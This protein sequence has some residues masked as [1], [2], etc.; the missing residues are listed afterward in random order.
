MHQPRP[1]G[2]F[3]AA[4][5]EDAAAAELL[6]RRVTN[7]KQLSGL[8]S[9]R[10]ARTLP[11]GAIAIA[12]DM[13]GVFKVIVQPRVLERPPPEPTDGL[14]RSFIPMLF[15]GA[16]D[17]GRVRNDL[18]ASQREGIEL[19][20]SADT[21]RRLAGYDPE[22]AAKI[23]ERVKLQR[24]VVELGQ[25]FAELM[26]Y[27]PPEV[28]T[29]TQYDSLRPTWYSGAM[30]EVVQIVGGYGRQDF[31]K[32]PD[33]PLERARMALPA[34][35]LRA[36][37]NELGNRRL[38][39]YTGFPHEDGQIRYDYKYNE[40]HAVGFDGERKP[41][42]LRIS[43]A[44]VYAMPLPMIP[45]TTTMAFRKHVEEKQDEELKWV[46][47]RFGGLP[48]GEG[49]PVIAKDF[50]AWRRAGVITQV[51][52][53]GD[54]YQHLMYTSAMGW[55]LNS[56]GTE[57]FNTCHDYDEATQVSYSYGY[58]LRLS[59]GA[60]KDQGKLPDAF[61]LK[62][63]EQS[64]MLDAYLSRLY[65][66]L[67]ANGARELAIKYK[68]RRV[69][70]AELLQR[71]EKAL[72]DGASVQAEVDHWDN[73]QAPPIASHGGSVS[74]V[75]SGPVPWSMAGFKLPE[76]FMQGCISYKAPVKPKPGHGV[77]KADTI[78][79]GYYVGDQLKVIKY[80]TDE[81]Q[82]QRGVEDNY[83]DCM[84]VGSW[85]RTITE[86]MTGLMGSY[87]TSDFDEREAAADTTT[88]IH[89]VGTDLGYDTKP[90]FSYDEWFWRPGTIWR[91]R[92]FKHLTH[93]EKVTGYSRTVA[94]CMPYLARNA[95]LHARTDSYTGKAITDDTG[96]FHITDP[97]SYRYWT[98]DFVWAWIGGVGGPQAAV[99]V[100]PK[101]GNPVW[102]VQENY[103]PGL[104]SDFA[105][106]GPWIPGLPADYTWLV[107]P[108]KHRWDFSGGGGAPS[109]NVGSS[110]KNEPGKS[111]GRLDLSI[112]ADPLKVSAEPPANMYYLFSPDPFVGMFY[113]DAIK[114]AAGKCEYANVSEAHPSIKNARAFQGWCRLADHSTAHH[115]IGVINE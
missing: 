42:L 100:Y 29:V 115:F 18:P 7:L 79:A 111:T 77:R 12:Q 97:Y 22:K 8:D 46:L 21:R 45:A 25:R 38:P 101:D 98:N 59:L 52:G 23:K 39:G 49:F 67:R 88:T 74:R 14:A 19:R 107:H 80:F 20:L 65:E 68:L 61:D 109:V 48:S 76:P 81:R 36:I 13:G 96:L 71:A 73:L 10:M 66:L 82:Y 69:P 114:V 51:C 55:S 57:G 106:R 26:P 24:F 99:P 63:P 91:N 84:I 17:K 4:T 64:R 56:R 37:E 103:A 87:Y 9:L 72:R 89:T 83:E 85:D 70:V 93:T 90:F 1:H 108:D 95:V 27:P 32:L 53:V 102:V 35:A 6:A 110:G 30:A 112:L 28:W 86:G 113:R 43:T 62:D 16:I 15:S 75:A 94:V 58:K 104:C 11:S 44:G 33:T 60:A 41:W 78:L 40:T 2:T 54:F 34:K 47:D 5:E 105:D 92:Y 31:K 50:Q 3:G